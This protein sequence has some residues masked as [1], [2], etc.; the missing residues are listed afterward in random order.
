VLKDQC[1]PPCRFLL[2]GLLL[3]SASGRQSGFHIGC[4]G[5]SIALSRRSTASRSRP[6]L[7]RRWPPQRQPCFPIQSAHHRCQ[8]SR[9]SSTEHQP[10]SWPAWRSR[11]HSHLPR[12][13]SAPR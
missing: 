4:G 5:A 1:P 2:R 9:C 3:S 6:L 13:P 10:A 12:P 7:P 11:V 8:H